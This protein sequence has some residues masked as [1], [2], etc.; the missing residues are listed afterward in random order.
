MTFLESWE[1]TGKAGEQLVLCP[2]QL[3]PGV[4][5]LFFP[6]VQRKIHISLWNL[7]HLLVVVSSATSILGFWIIKKKDFKRKHFTRNDILNIRGENIFLWMEMV[8]CTAFNWTFFVCLASKSYVLVL[9]VELL[10]FFTQNYMT[11]RY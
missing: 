8:I 1:L 11:W 9:E 6:V 7:A 4:E 2:V 5:Y 10:W 3:F